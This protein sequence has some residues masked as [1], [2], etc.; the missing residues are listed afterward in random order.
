MFFCMG[1][2]PYVSCVARCVKWAYH[3]SQ[4]L[5]NY[6]E[7]VVVAS[8]KNRHRPRYMRRYESQGACREHVQNLLHAS[9]CM[10]ILQSVSFVHF[11]LS[12]AP[13]SQHPLAAHWPCPFVF[14]QPCARVLLCTLLAA[15]PVT[16]WCVLQCYALVTV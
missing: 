14:I 5:Q 4:P 1:V 16:L 6:I 12:V 3:I 2:Y 13:V 9:M 8:D 10:V 11:G 15:W 7:I